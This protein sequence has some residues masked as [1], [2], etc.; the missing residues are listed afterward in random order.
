MTAT[1]VA[2]GRSSEPSGLY[3][4]QHCRDIGG[5]LWITYSTLGSLDLYRLDNYPDPGTLHLHPTPETCVGI[6]AQ[7]LASEAAHR[8]GHG[9]GERASV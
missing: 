9:G 8:D 2:R 6:R 4:R 5:L 1:G 3:S 7:Q